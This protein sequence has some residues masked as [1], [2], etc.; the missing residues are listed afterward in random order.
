MR[1]FDLPLGRGRVLDAG[2]PTAIMGILNITPDSFSDGGS[3]ADL[4]EVVAAAKLM[5]AAG[6]LVLDV[7]GES[8]RPMADAI[9]LEHELRRV[10]PVVRALVERIGIPISVDTTKAAV[11]DEAWRAGASILND[12]S[13]L[14]EDPSLSQVV[15][16]TDAAVI[17]MHRRGNPR[18]MQSMAN[19]NAVVTDVVAELA[20]A[21]SRAESAGIDSR[22]VILDPGLGFAK[23]AEHN[24][25]LLAQLDQLRMG[26]YPLCVGPSRKAFL[27]VLTGRTDPKDRD[28]ATAVVVAGC[29]KASVELVRVHHV[30]FAADAVKVAEAVSAAGVLP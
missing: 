21:V 26:R 8:T 4:E 15:A 29:A 11:F 17:L 5:V 6:A 12:V 3:Y 18:T 19:Y 16:R 20:L 22:R 23:S 24:L 7:G 27:G 28:V 30:G 9:S 1:R 2:G 14:S 25:A 10:V 13:G